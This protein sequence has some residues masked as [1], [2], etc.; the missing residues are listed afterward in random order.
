MQL[1]LMRNVLRAVRAWYDVTRSYMEPGADY[2]FEIGM[3]AVIIM[4]ELPH[5]D[6]L[7]N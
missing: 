6:E 1:R 2:Q 4:G 3:I 7:D 5:A